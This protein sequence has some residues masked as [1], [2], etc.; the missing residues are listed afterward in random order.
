MNDADTDLAM[1]VAQAENLLAE[2]ADRK[3]K[4]GGLK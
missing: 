1:L 2:I 3:A 4:K